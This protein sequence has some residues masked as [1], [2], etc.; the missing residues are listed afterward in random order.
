[1]LLLALCLYSLSWD[2]SSFDE[3]DYWSAETPTATPKQTLTPLTFATTDPTPSATSNESSAAN[4]LTSVAMICIYVAFALVIIMGVVAFVILYRRR[5]AK[6]RE[7]ENTNLPQ[8]LQD[9]LVD[10]GQEGMVEI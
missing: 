5:K 4:F 10:E 2:E 7:F 3:S 6:D 9:T 8:G 1:M